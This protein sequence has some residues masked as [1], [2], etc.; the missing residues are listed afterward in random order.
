MLIHSSRAAPAGASRAAPPAAAGA[1]GEA[2][3][4]GASSSE[5]PPEED[6]APSFAAASFRRRFDRLLRRLLLLLRALRIAPALL[7]RVV[8][9]DDADPGE[10]RRAPE[11]IG[12]RARLGG[13]KERQGRRGERK[14]I[15][16]DHESWRCRVPPRLIVDHRRPHSRGPAHRIRRRQI[17]SRARPGKPLIS[18][19]E[20]RMAE[21]TEDELLQMVRVDASRSSRSRS[22]RSRERPPTAPARIDPAGR[23]PSPASTRRLTTTSSPH[24]LLRVACPPRR[25]P[26]PCSRRRRKPET[27]PPLNPNLHPRRT[28]RPRSPRAT[29]RSRSVDEPNSRATRRGGGSRGGD[30]C[31]SRTPA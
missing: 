16:V 2:R 7:L 19:R 17:S 15:V 8:P 12:A 10:H 23:S 28:L 1:G 22:P 6:D 30:P 9:R 4:D 26:C 11:R 24:S 13:P 27:R 20:A 3:G 21:E 29:P 25:S 5:P 14:G 18:S 31:W